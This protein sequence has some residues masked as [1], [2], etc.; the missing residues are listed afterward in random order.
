MLE[1]SESLSQPPPHIVTHVT[2]P[3]P[4]SCECKGLGR[5]PHAQRN[6]SNESYRLEMAFRHSLLPSPELDRF[7]LVAALSRNAWP[8]S[9]VW[10]LYEVT[11]LLAYIGIVIA[12]GLTFGRC[13]PPDDFG[14]FCGTYDSLHRQRRA[15]ALV[16]DAYFSESLVKTRR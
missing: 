13:N 15:I 2:V 5:S 9:A 7:C 1:H 14:I 6:A 4:H 11:R 12:A 10:F 3:V 16:H 8:A